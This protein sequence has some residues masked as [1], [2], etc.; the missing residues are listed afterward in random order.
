MD[1]LF[2][3]AVFREFNITDSS[4]SN[5]IKAS[6]SKILGKTK[7]NVEEDG[8]H[9]VKVILKKDDKDSIKEIRFICSCGQSKSII[10]DYSE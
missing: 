3:E 7:I 8:Q 10:L 2:E 5:V 9:G 6:D 1:N 4:K